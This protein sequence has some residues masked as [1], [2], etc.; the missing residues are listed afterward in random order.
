MKTIS[1]INGLHHLIVD[2]T[3]HG[4]Y[5]HREDAVREM[6]RLEKLELQSIFD[7]ID[8]NLAAYPVLETPRKIKYP[9][10]IIPT[11]RF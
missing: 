4:I 1:A 10:R 3:L 7:R 5:G 9:E 2:G 11:P 6:A 8:A